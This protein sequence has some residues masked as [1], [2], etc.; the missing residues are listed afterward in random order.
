MLEWIE[1]GLK[2]WSK[3]Q[4]ADGSFDEAY[5]FERS[6]A[7]TAFTTFYIGEALEFVGKSLSH[8]TMSRV[9]QTMAKSGDW[10]V[11]NDETHG[12]LSNHLAAAVAALFH[13]YRMTGDEKFEKRSRYFLRKI[14]DHQSSEGWYQ[15]YGGADPGYQ[16]HGSFY[17]TR[18]WELTQDQELY[19]SLGRSVA[20]LSYF[21]H[22]DGSLGGE[23]T[24]RNTQ[25]YY[26]AAFEKLAQYHSGAGWIAD[27]M[28]PSVFNAAAAGIKC[29]D[30]YNYFPF[31]NNLVF[32]YLACQDGRTSRP[33]PF[34]PSNQG[35]L[36][37]FPQAGMLRMQ[38]QF[39]EAFVGTCKGGVMKVFD[40]TRNRSVYSDCGYMGSLHDGRMIST[41][42]HDLHRR[43]DVTNN[44]VEIFGNFF[45]VSRPQMTPIRFLG[46]RLFN[47]TLG[48]LAF[49]GRWLK[50]YLVEILIYR[51]VAVNIQFTRVIEFEDEYVRVQDHLKG[52]DGKRVRHLQWGER[53]T[54][55]HMGSSRYFV[56][57]ELQKFDKG[58]SA[59]KE[60]DPQNLSSGVTLE[61]LVSFHGDKG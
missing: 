23:Y 2:F 27:T 58:G 37:Y 18:Y 40:R 5:P 25:T 52:P 16:T 22:P 48:R 32:A 30:I 24:S 15:E 49:L 35:G 50:H 28:R 4:Y 21:I 46:F 31:L 1:S 11:Q 29:V 10:L 42:Y 55:I 26:P 7:A 13:V 6:L 61:R 19:E 3:I 9:R 17:L 45:E 14:L 54:T 53:F 56:M 60:I 57:N 38:T 47:V 59:K 34:P 20:W 41:H 36:T 43:I 51:K 12:L 44:R 39:Y 8:D 33:V